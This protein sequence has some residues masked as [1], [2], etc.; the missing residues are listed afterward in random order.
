[1]TS[2]KTDLE[3]NEV[4]VVLMYFYNH[5]KTNILFSRELQ[6]TLKSSFEYQN[7]ARKILLPEKLRK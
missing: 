6:I 1:M 5:G 7:I 2:L 4:V 3:Q